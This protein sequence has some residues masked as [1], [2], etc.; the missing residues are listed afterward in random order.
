MKGPYAVSAKAY[1]SLKKYAIWAL[2]PGTVTYGLFCYAKH[3]YK[4]HTLRVSEVIPKLIGADTN[5]V[6]ITV[7]QC[8]T[9]AR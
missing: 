9:R 2:F 4:N 1:P 7:N 6:S 8:Q 5:V 3:L